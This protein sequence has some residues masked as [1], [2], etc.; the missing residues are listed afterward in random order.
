[1]RYIHL[2]HLKHYDRHTGRFNS[3]AFKGSSDGSG[4]SIILEQ[5]GVDDSGSICAHIQRYYA[6]VGGEPPVF[7]RF[8]DSALDADCR[9][10]QVD[11]ERGDR[12]HHEVK[13]P[14]R[15]ALNKRLRKQVDSW[16]IEDLWICDREGGSDRPLRRSDV[17]PE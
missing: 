5:C 7:W 3:L 2:V 1:M 16:N 17:P 8:D 9:I 4:A 15:T 14:S 11:S 13:G 6:G 12:C 10:E